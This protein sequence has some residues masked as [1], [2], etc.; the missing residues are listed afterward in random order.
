MNGVNVNSINAWKA[1]LN[2]HIFVYCAHRRKYMQHT[3]YT[4][5]NPTYFYG[6][7]EMILERPLC[8]ANFSLQIFL[9]KV[10]KIDYKFFPAGFVQT[11]ILG[12]TIKLDSYGKLPR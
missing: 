4:K 8:Q 11:I 1:I 9:P 3:I 6:K 12:N 5:E 7:L 10:P 2:T